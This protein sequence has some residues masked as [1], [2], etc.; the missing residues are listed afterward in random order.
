MYYD[1]SIKILL[2][3]DDPDYAQIIRLMMI[4]EMGVEVDLECSSLLKDAITRLEKEDKEG[5]DVV[6][7]DLTLPDSCG[8]DTFAQVYARAMELP[9][10]VLTCLD[11]EKLATEAVREGAQDYLIKDQV[12]S[13]L[14]AR[15]IKYAI[16]RK[17][18]DKELKKAN[19][20]LKQ[21]QEKL[22]LWNKEL[23]EEVKKRTEA[24]MKANQELEDA[25]ENL[26]MMDREKTKFLST[27]AHDLR[28]PL[29]AIKAYADMMLMYK[30]EP[31]EVREEF[32]N[33][34]IHE[35][36]RVNRLI[37]N[38]LNLARIELNTMRYEMKPLDM[39]A[40][41]NQLTSSHKKQTN[42]LGLSLMADIPD[43]LP[44]VLGDQKRIGQVIANLLS[45][46]IKFTPPGGKIKIDVKSKSDQ[47]IH[48]TANHNI[49]VSVSDTGIG[50]PEQYHQKIFEKFG[51]AQMS[52]K[53]AK[54]GLGLGLAIAKHIVEHHGGRIWVESE[55]GKGSRFS[56]TLPVKIHQQE[57]GESQVG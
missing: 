41:I 44:E 32:I 48:H 39:N 13:K 2:I 12:D 46:A 23:E 16:E 11:D 17:E 43:N 20:R 6:L 56:F 42:Q 38:L 36:D 1:E 51:R 50:I 14:L 47:G 5:I 29:T 9:I 33:I 55:E 31:A 24:L 3:E 34:I 49:C 19:I 54:E 18:V 21:S 52:S 10:V 25:N 37:D 53:T 26:R 57:K 40:L 28:T 45:N 15:S 4:K 30:D 7:M 22:E 27:V 8:F 35:S